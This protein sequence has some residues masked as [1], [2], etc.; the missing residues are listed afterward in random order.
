MLKACYVRVFM[1]KLLFCTTVALQWI[2]LII[3]SSENCENMHH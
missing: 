1:K 2:L 3:S